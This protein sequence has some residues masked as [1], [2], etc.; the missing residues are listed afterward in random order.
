MSQMF[1]REQTA[2]EEVANSIS[3]GVGTLLSVAGAV[4]AIVTAVL[5]STAI[6]I[7]SASLY[8]ASLILL[9]GFSTIY[10]S[11]TNKRIKRI[12]RV[13]DH[14]AIFILILGSYIPIC[15]TLIGGALGWTLFGVNAACTIIGV[16]FISIDLERWKKLSMVLYLIMGWSIVASI[17]PFLAVAD[18]AGLPLLVGGGIAYTAGVIFYKA[19]PKYMHFVW[20]IF[21]MAG[22]VLQYFFMLFYVFMK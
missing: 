6:G 3:H 15:L 14:C 9:Y 7:V 22:S 18:P 12:F 11:I 17:K 1:L 2:G 4:I 13:F 20:H 16:V 19:R 8:G 10:H 5:Y 21:V